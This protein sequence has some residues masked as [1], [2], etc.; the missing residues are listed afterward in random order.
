MAQAQNHLQ[1]SFYRNFDSGSGETGSEVVALEGDLVFVTNGFEQRI[2]VFSIASG[3]KVGEVDLS[4]I[5]G[6]AGVNSVA[7]KNGVLVAAVETAPVLNSEGVQLVANNGY[8]A[9]FSVPTLDS[10]G[11]VE[12]GVLP[13]MVTFAPD[14][15][16]VLVA[17]EGEPNMDAQF[18]APG[19]ISIIDISGGVGAAVAAHLD[20]SGYDATV[21]QLIA[22]GVRLFPDKLPSTDFEPEYIAVSA[23]GSTA[24]VTL[25]EANTVAVIDLTSNSISTLLPLGTVDHLNGIELASGEIVP[26]GLDASDRDGAINIQPQPLHGMRM[27]DAIAA[28][29][30]GGQNYFATANEG[31]ARDEDVRVKDL[32]LDPTAFP[33]A[34]ELQ[35]DGALGRMTVS[36]IDGD[37]DGDGAFEQLFS[38]GSRSFTIF[39]EAG[40]VVFDSGSQFEEILAEL[41]PEQFNHDLGEFDARSDNKGPEP[42]AIAVGEMNGKLYAFIGLERDGGVMIYDISN[43]ASA[44][45][46]GYID[47]AAGG[48]A[49]PE[50]IQFIPADESASGLPQI[51]VAYEVSGTTALIDIEQVMNADG[52][53]AFSGKTHAGMVQASYETLLDRAGD[54]AGI[55]YWVS[56]LE[57]GRSLSEIIGGMLDSDEFASTPLG[58]ADDAAFLDQLYVA[59]L[60]RAG[61][62][63]GIEYWLGDLEGGALRRDVAASFLESTEFHEGV[64]VEL[65]GSGVEY[66]VWVG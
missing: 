19:G 22:D 27:P 2:D 52:V 39:D 11:L 56:E 34:A 60:G 28:F 9:F 24:Y 30:I 8:A 32:A 53:V 12:V 3:E 61:D 64:L 21:D 43:P 42:E 50:I 65:V 10:L 46:S 5:P 37:I 54:A 55:G 25:Q 14:G 58:A 48:H 62:A 29:S 4:A 49:S 7:V 38:Y 20:F 51:A 26:A 16:T 35:A 6:F 36:S 1:Y 13:D 18:D 40:N 47:S 23:D 41:R 63:A 45:Y 31:D 59:T 57:G 17:N 66:E 33:N 15:N 44:T